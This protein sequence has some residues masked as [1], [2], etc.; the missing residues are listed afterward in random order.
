MRS[1]HTHI[2]RRITM[3]TKISMNRLSAD[4]YRCDLGRRVPRDCS[5]RE[6][7]EKTRYKLFFEEVVAES[8]PLRQPTR[9]ES[10]I[11]FSGNRFCSHECGYIDGT[12]VLEGYGRLGLIPDPTALAY[13]FS[14]LP[15][16]AEGVARIACPWQ[17]HDGEWCGVEFGETYCYST[18]RLRCYASISR[19]GKRGTW[20]S[21]IHT[22]F[23][24]F[25]GVRDSW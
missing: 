21:T 2:Q 17:D 12:S 25:A 8:I 5:P 10:L 9:D 19:K 18:G 16:L 4:L 13:V 6:I 20:T 3:T 14:Q 23:I 24:W 1:S 15:E 22:G 7:L 11:V